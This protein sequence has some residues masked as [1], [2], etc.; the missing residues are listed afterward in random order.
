MLLGGKGR[1]VR[2][3]ETRRGRGRRALALARMEVVEV[4]ELGVAE[5]EEEKR[6]Y[7]GYAIILSRGFSQDFCR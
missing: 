4:V 1:D 2:K 6:V 7:L 5:E 3:R